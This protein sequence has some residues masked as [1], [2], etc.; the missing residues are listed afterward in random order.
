MSLERVCISKNQ[1]LN[2]P[3]FPERRRG[4]C[5]CVCTCGAP[6]RQPFILRDGKTSQTLCVCG[7]SYPTLR[8]VKLL[9]KDG[10]EKMSRFYSHRGRT[11]SPSLL[12]PFPKSTLLTVSVFV[13]GLGVTYFSTQ[14]IS[15][16]HRS[17]IYL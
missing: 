3:I 4:V 6:S 14:C 13:F 16:F 1:F 2:A 8:I 5:R 15:H 9:H 10:T 7:V 12:E 11:H 17:I